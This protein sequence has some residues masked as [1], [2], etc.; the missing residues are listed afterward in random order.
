MPVN[1]TQCSGGCLGLPGRAFLKH[2]AHYTSLAE[3]CGRATNRRAS[4]EMV[5][6]TSPA[7]DR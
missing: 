3:E 5:G 2:K 4:L 6:G 7:V 1:P